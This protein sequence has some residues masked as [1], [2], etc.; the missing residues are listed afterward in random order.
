MPFVPGPSYSS[1]RSG[2]PNP[3]DFIRRPYFDAIHDF[4]ARGYA[5]H[6]V[7]IEEQCRKHTDDPRKGKNMWVLGLLCALYDLDDTPVKDGIARRFAKK[8]D[9]VV[10][11]NLDLLE[12][13]YRWGLDNLDQRFSVPT[14]KS[15][16]PMVVMN[17]NQAMALGPHGGGDRS[18]LHVSHHAS[19]IGVPFPRGESGA[20]GRVRPSG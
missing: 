17:G 1:I 6:E 10:K 11:K 2:A 4:E 12:D 7:P 14:A 15:T 8:G 20:G 13:G 3:D 9:A 18:L 19:H 5:V 16:E